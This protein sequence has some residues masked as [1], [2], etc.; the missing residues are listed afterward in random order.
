[1]RHKNV[2]KERE[3]SKWKKKDSNIKISQMKREKKLVERKII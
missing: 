2:R 3:I 1:M